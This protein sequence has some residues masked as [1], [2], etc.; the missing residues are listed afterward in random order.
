MTTFAATSSLKAFAVYALC[1]LPVLSTPA[2]AVGIS[3]TLSTREDTPVVIPLSKVSDPG[4]STITPVRMPEAGE[5]RIT[6]AGEQV[7]VT[8]LPI[9]CKA[10]S[11]SELQWIPGFNQLTPTS[12]QFRV[13]ADPAVYTLA[14][15]IDTPVNDT[16]TLGNSVIKNGSFLGPVGPQLFPDW[17][18][19]LTSA[20]AP[21]IGHSYGGAAFNSGNSRPGGMLQ[22]VME[23]V[24]GTVYTV[25]LQMTYGG[26]P[27]DLQQLAISVADGIPNASAPFGSLPGTALF[28]QTYGQEDGKKVFTFTAQSAETSL[29][30]ADITPVGTSSA[31]DPGEATVNSDIALLYINAF[32]S[33]PAQQLLEDGSLTFSRAKLNGFTASDDDGEVTPYTLTASVSHGTLTPA[34]T[35]GLSV[36][37]VPS[38]LVGYRLEGTLANINLA[39]EGLVYT[40]NPNYNGADTLV[41]DLHDNGTN[42][43]SGVCPLYPNAYAPVPQFCDLST[44]LQI[45][46]TIIPVNDA[47]A[48]TDKS[49]ITVAAYAPYAFNAADFG[50]TDPVDAAFAS[51]ANRLLAVRIASLPTTGTLTLA[52]AAVAAGQIV[53]VASIPQLTWTAAGSPGTDVSRFTFQVQDD[54]GTANGGVDLGPIANTISFNVT[55]NNPPAAADD[56]YAMQQGGSA[57]VLNPLAKASDPD[58]EALRLVSL[59]GTALTPGTA[60]TIAVPNGSVSISDSGAISFTPD[61]AYAGTLNF[62]YVVA[63][64]AGATASAAIS[65][66]VIPTATVAPPATATPVPG[67][68]AGFT[69]LVTALLAGLGAW[70]LRGKRAA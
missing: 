31:T 26:I 55:A 61:P 36:T 35:S 41:L 32:G 37:P 28:S 1:W 3:D 68:D 42:N 25:N 47:P 40:P 15:R 14:L 13:D 52:G 30:I 60:Q 44:Q 56:P 19:N 27:T 16:P 49:G 5:G 34:S 6:N 38:P 53:P 45:P 65:I 69:L 2:L 67:G 46:L 17:Q 21:N 8:G 57:L 54:G 59:N 43:L 48:G 11:E 18:D 66:T 23:T 10:I 22:Q 33:P 70:R 50:F 63:D 7:Y 24:P 4:C 64:P 12:F 29:R 20:S 51:G 39:L 9:T 62:P 58:G